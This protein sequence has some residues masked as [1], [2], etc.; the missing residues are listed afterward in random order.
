MRTI[1]ILLIMGVIGNGLM[2]QTAL[3]LQGQPLEVFSNKTEGL[4]GVLSKPQ[5]SPF[6]SQVF[7]F[8]RRDGEKQYLYYY[9]MAAKSLTE[10][11]TVVR[12]AGVK[13]SLEDSLRYER[14]YSEQLDWRPGLDA[15][16][17]QWFAFVSNGADDNPD[18][19]LGFA[20]STTYIRLTT[21][22][23]VDSMPRWSPDGNALAFISHRSGNGDIYLVEEVNRIISDENR[24][25]D[26]F[27]LRQV[28]RTPQPESEIRWNP[29]PHA[30]LLAYTI[31]MRFPGRQ[32]PTNQIKILDLTLTENN[33]FDLTNDP[34]ANYSRPVWDPQHGNRIL[35][36]GQG[37]LAGETA[38]L[39]LV[40]LKW[41][42]EGR[43]ANSVMDGY[44]IEIF[45]NVHLKGTH[46]LWLAGGEAILC[47]ENRP[48]QNYPIYSVNI[49]RRLENKER[50]IY[51]FGKLHGAYPFILEFD[52]RKNNLIF[53]NQEGDTFKIYLAQM[54]GDD[55][56]PY[57]IPE[58]A[59]T[60]PR[61]EIAA[62]TP[63][64][65]PA[66][67]TAKVQTSQKVGAKFLGIGIP[68]LIGGG[69]AA[70]GAATW[71][72]LS[73]N[74]EGNTGRPTIGLP[75]SMP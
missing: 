38:N 5:F 71:M 6:P 73:G 20:G 15:Q 63:V 17:R 28:T 37:L 54:Y 72:L 2:A 36:V 26:N 22:A 25:P 53:V 31:Q 66:E 52:V 43:L 13:L 9:D 33:V 60:N 32:V 42:E 70:V 62:V 46:A 41:S 19:Y 49:S 24:N 1:L 34:L 8:E 18:I 75:P 50:S 7:S 35:F 12:Q 57:A 16:G 10:V 40:E 11:R 56:V 29:D 69:A 48:E 21:D 30:H 55:I 65:P 51:Y 3:Q 67:P 44:K 14:V 58:F 23:A 64:I 68:Y 74:G 61:T 47:Q 45:Q 39:Y 27:K 59:L 4:S